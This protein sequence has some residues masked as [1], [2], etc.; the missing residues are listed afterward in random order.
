MA[1][2]QGLILAVV[3]KIVDAG[4]LIFVTWL[5]YV[6]VIHHVWWVEAWL[7]GQRLILLDHTLT[8]SSKLHI[9]PHVLFDCSIEIFVAI[10]TDRD[11]TI[12]F[13]YVYW[14]FIFLSD[15]CNFLVTGNKL[16]QV[17]LVCQLI[18][19]WIFSVSLKV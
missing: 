6:C 11:Q 19:V 13:M 1:K 18:N 17:L 8:V 2:G 4:T 9:F 7:Q 3:V 12:Y 5:T 15:L 16:N 14:S 10:R